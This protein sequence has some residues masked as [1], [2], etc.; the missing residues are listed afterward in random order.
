MIVAILGI[1][2]SGCGYLPI[3][4]NLPSERKIFMLEDSS[5]RFL[6]LQKKFG[7]DIEKNIWK[8]IFIDS[9]VHKV[10]SIKNNLN[11]PIASSNVAYVIYTSGTTGV[12]KGVVVKHTGVVNLMMSNSKYFSFSATDVWT[13]FHSHAFDFSIWEM[14]GALLFGGQLILV[15]NKINKN[16]KQYYY[17]LIKNEVTV[18]SVT[19]TEYEYLRKFDRENKESKLKLKYLFIGGEKWDFKNLWSWKRENHRCK[20]IHVYG[21]TE[22]TIICVFKEVTYNDISNNIYSIGKPVA[23]TNIYILDECNKLVAQGVIGEICISGKGVSAGYLNREELT[24]E[25][26]IE[27]PFEENEVLYKTGDLGRVLPNDEIEF[28]GRNDHQVK[29][30]GYRIE[31][32]EIEIILLQHL[33]VT[34]AKVV[35]QNRNDDQYICAYYTGDLSDNSN[36]LKEFLSLKLPSYMVPH[37][38]VYLKNMPIAHT[39]KIDVDAL[40][41]P[42]FKNRD[43]YIPPETEIEIR[44]VNIWASI[45]EIEKEQIGITDNFFDLGGHS[46][47]I[48]NIVAA[49][50]EEFN[51]YVPLMAIYEIPY[52][53]SIAEIIDTSVSIKKGVHF[54]NSQKSKKIFCMPPGISFGICYKSLSDNLKDYCL[55][56][57]NYIESDNFIGD[58]VDEIIKIQPESPYI[59]MGYSGGGKTIYSIACELE[60]RG[61]SISHIISIDGYWDEY[62]HKPNV[63]NLY[64]DTLEVIKA[65]NLH[66]FH[67][68]VENNIRQYDVFMSKIKFSKKVDSKIHFLLSEGV[69]KIESYE[70]INTEKIK[71]LNLMNKFAQKTTKVYKAH[72]LHNKMINTQ[73]GPDNAEIIKN[74]LEN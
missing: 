41:N 71:V 57:F 19:P 30:R 40:P 37:F 8:E 36:E 44:L 50:K 65:S 74:I 14:F 12:P 27:N 22:A 9:D 62:E 58:T 43:N 73:Y 72:G 64:K 54:F 2:K 61:K 6:L 21:P 70:H 29:I 23:N 48:L 52:I 5:S 67:S 10:G 56:A 28:F 17:S 34:A 49:I 16:I 55:C 18:L 33:K 1:M 38:F 66:H 13:M 45:L 68:E 46:L 51:T 32:N 69:E 11:V 31:L 24:R 39:G 26:F 47:K 60:R 53:K 20:T 15:S 35:M 59:L 42:I 63:T 7:R 4:P 25:K 3:D